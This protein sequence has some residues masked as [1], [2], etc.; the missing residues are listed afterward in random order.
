MLEKCS[1]IT[2]FEWKDMGRERGNRHRPSDVF[3]LV[4]ASGRDALHELLFSTPKM[5]PTS[6]VERH[7]GCWGLV[8]SKLRYLRV[9][10]GSSVP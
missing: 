9:P 6:S 2:A 10:M 8:T 1:L 5:R 3:I 4:D 7:K